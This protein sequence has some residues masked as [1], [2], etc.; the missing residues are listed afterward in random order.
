MRKD[1]EE[2]SKKYENMRILK[3]TND[4]KILDLTKENE[5]K[6]SRIE[7]LTKERIRGM[8]ELERALA[9]NTKY[10]ELYK[11]SN[12]IENEPSQRL[13]IANPQFAKEVPRITILTPSHI[14]DH[15]MKPQKEENNLNKTTRSIKHEKLITNYTFDESKPRNSIGERKNSVNSKCI[16][17]KINENIVKSS[18]RTNTDRIDREKTIL[19]KTSTQNNDPK[20]LFT[21]QCEDFNAKLAEF[22]QTFESKS[23]TKTHI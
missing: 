13:K 15:D 12:L 17:F 7:E 2:L 14:K 6:N 4:Q 5:I 16:F 20:S 3:E 1:Y 9:E 8:Q 21:Q 19:N 23:P 18:I 11:K 10:L 22:K